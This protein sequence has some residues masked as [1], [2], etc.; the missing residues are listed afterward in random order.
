MITVAIL[1][2]SVSQV[3]LHV[4]NCLR[5]QSSQLH[6]HV[7]ASEILLYPTLEKEALEFYNGIVNLVCFVEFK[8]RIDCIY[9][10]QTS[11]Y[12]ISDSGNITSIFSVIV[13]DVLAVL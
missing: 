1:R 10:K 8:I 12:N 11:E 6:S 9:D 3:T 13:C 7:C 4:A 2:I 5:L